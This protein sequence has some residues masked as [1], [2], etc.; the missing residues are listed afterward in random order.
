MRFIAY[1]CLLLMFNAY[2]QEASWQIE[3]DTANIFSSP[4]FCDLNSDGVQ[5]IVIGGGVESVPSS[6]GVMAINGDNGEL[7]WKVP[8]RTQIYTSALFQDITGDGVQDVFIGGRAAT[9]MTINGA[10]GKIIW[11]FFNG[12]EKQSREA[13]IL[14]F[15]GTQFIDDQNGDGIK[16]LL[17]TNGGDYLA[18]P[19]DFTRASARLMV[20]N[21]L[22]G[23]VINEVWV[24]D[25][26]ESYYAPHVYE[27]KGKEMVL[28][29]T[30]GETIG[31]SLW[32]LPLKSL[33]N[34]SAKKIK[35]VLTDS[36]KGFILNSVIADV[37]G[38]GQADILS[39][40]MNAS[41]SAV[42]GKNNKLIWNNKYPGYECYVTPSLGQFNED[43]IPDLFTIIAKGTF[44]AYETFDV[45]VLDGAS[46]DEIYRE[47]TGFNQF[48]PAISVDMNSDG[49]DEI[50]YV[51][52]HMDFG[53]YKL[54]NRLRIIDL[55]SKETQEFGPVRDGMS[56]ASAPS[57]VDLDG[58]GEF[59]IIVATTVP[60][61][62][63]DAQP[64]SI[65]QRV[66]LNEIPGSFNWPGYLGPKENGLYIK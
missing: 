35:T 42:D 37:T 31:G 8:C 21:S 22:T 57:I 15:F 41:I 26:K 34:N 66:K 63:G 18:A 58:D 5:D 50:I 52:N 20:L 40:G 4:R 6:N 23:E 45:L 56:M 33:L 62:E 1:C 59:E 38:D 27:R 43:N 17:V 36:D 25:K 48:S 32:S 16:D 51:Q 19:N 39:A 29:G 7:L 10:T 47:N 60:V 49:L 44:P 54:D 28:F 65:I 11:Q 24:T 61:M 64:T 2:S 14:N 55:K 46:G 9:Y 53:S 12:T 30:G 13:G 3:F